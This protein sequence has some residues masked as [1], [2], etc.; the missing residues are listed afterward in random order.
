M[1]TGKR[2]TITQRIKHL[3][4]HSKIRNSARMKPTTVFFN[5]SNGTTIAEAINI[6]HISIFG[7]C[8]GVR[9]FEQH[10]NNV[11]IDSHSGQ[12][13]PHTDSHASE[14]GAVRRERRTILGAKFELLYSE[15]VLTRE[16]FGR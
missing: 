1:S 15:I 10:S 8:E 11:T 13:T 9:H 2:T 4:K 16:Q 12:P 5:S 7:I 14:S 6:E 3:G